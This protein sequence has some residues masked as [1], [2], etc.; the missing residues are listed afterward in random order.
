MFSLL[1][2]RL[3]ELGVHLLFPVCSPDCVN[4][5]CLLSGHWFREGW[6]FSLLRSEHFK[7]NREINALFGNFHD[8]VLTVAA[9]TSLSWLV[10]RASS[11]PNFQA[12]FW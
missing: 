9:R 1:Q 7:D 6:F 12:S 10:I 8:D 4:H 2:S 5:R 11:L 3:E